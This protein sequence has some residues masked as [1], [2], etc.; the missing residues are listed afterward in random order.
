MCDLGRDEIVQAGLA[1]FPAGYVYFAGCYNEAQ[2]PET[3]NAL[4]KAEPELTIKKQEVAES[5]AE[6]VPAAAASSGSADPKDI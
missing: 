3:L 5:T 2:L 1:G 4:T 6:A